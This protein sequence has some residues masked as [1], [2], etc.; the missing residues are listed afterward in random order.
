MLALIT[1][2]KLQ[3]FVSGKK[4]CFRRFRDF[5]DLEV[6]KDP[7]FL[8]ITFLLTVALTVNVNSHVLIPL[9]LKQHAGLPVEDIATVISVRGIGDLI[10]KVGLSW[11][12][13]RGR[14]TA[15]FSLWSS[16]VL[17]SILRSCKFLKKMYWTVFS[18]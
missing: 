13:D 4:S 8:N 6:L 16:V 3:T 1:A 18:L 11:M 15:R 14:V 2:T 7:V 12:L 5:F 9:Y 10:S 17:M